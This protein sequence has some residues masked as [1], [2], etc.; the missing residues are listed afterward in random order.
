LNKGRIIGSFIIISLLSARVQLFEMADYSAGHHQVR[1]EK[2]LK[3]WSREVLKSKI[4]D[5]SKRGC[6]PEFIK[7]AE[8]ATVKELECCMSVCSDLD[9]LKYI[10]EEMKISGD[11][12]FVYAAAVADGKVGVV[13]YLKGEIDVRS[14]VESLMDRLWLLSVVTASPEI[15][16]ERIGK[17]IMS[18]NQS[19]PELEKILGVS[20][21]AGMVAI[22]MKLVP[23]LI[24]DEMGVTCLP[25]NNERVVLPNMCLSDHKMKGKYGLAECI[26]EK[27]LVMLLV[28]F[29]IL[30]CGEGWEGFVDRG[31]VKMVG[32]NGVIVQNR[33]SKEMAMLFVNSAVDEEK[34][35]FLGTTIERCDRDLSEK[36]LWDP[37]WTDMYLLIKWGWKM[38]EGKRKFG[39][40]HLVVHSLGNA[41]PK[42][43][44]GDLRCLGSN[45]YWSWL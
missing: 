19:I 42:A 33:V 12:G 25:K 3:K 32:Y 34:K 6:Y 21:N 30:F 41:I 45:D 15:R 27:D 44:E 24:V 7:L 28:N 2:M 4:V 11:E 1:I 8:A 10:M 16:M 38:V 23:E 36:K 35:I 17:E 14:A 43:I 5:A 37:R 22:M 18:Y 9:I 20:I 40:I 26:I 31:E 29:E 13:E 39:R